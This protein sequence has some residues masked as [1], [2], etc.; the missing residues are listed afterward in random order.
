MLI[1]LFFLFV[2]I[3]L[4]SIGGGYAIIP[5]IQTEIVKNQGWLSEQAFTDIIAI[6]QMTPGPLAVNTSTFVG[7]RMAGVAGAV[8]ATAGC[9]ICGIVISLSLYRFFQ[10]HRDSKMIFE[11]LC[12]LKSAS[13]GLIASAAGTILLLTFFGSDGPPALSQLDLPAV[14]LF[15]GTFF[16]LRKFHANP[17]LLMTLCGAAG[18]LLSLI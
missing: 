10:R 13:L 9:V 7:M 2:R 16:C 4:L 14:L 15:S 5:M 12:G 1:T 11:L 3:G 17:I 18:G 8:A 6:S